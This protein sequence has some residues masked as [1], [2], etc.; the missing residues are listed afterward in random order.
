MTINS[1][2]RVAGPFEGNDSTVSFPFTFKV[3]DS[4]EVRVVAETG[5][6][7]TDLELGTDYTVTLNADQNAAPGGSVVLVNP[8]ATGVRLTLT[9]ALEM[10]QPVDLT[11]QGGFYPRVINSALDRL[12]ILLQQLASVVSRT[13]KFPLSDGPVG[14]LPGRSAR[15]GTVLA[16]DEATGE[17]VVGPDISSVNGVA[18]ALAAINTVAGSIVDVNTV[19]DNIDDLSNFSGVYYG[20]SATD[21]TARRDGSPLQVGDLYFSTVTNTM[22]AY[23]GSAWR[24]SVSGAVT[25]QNLS[26]NGVKTEFLLDY[27]PESEVLTN[28][29]IGG[30]YQQKST[31]ALGGA[32]G[33]VLIFNQ[34]PPVGTDNIE[35]VV[36]S[37]IPSDD[38]LRQ[39]LAAPGGAE[40]VA[41]TQAGAGAVTRTIQE[42]AR[43]TVSAED[44]AGTDAEKLAAGVQALGGLGGTL[45]LT[46][47]G[48]ST[49]TRLAYTTPVS[50][51]GTGGVYAAVDTT[52]ALSTEDTF[53]YS[54]SADYDHT[55]TSVQRLHLG[56]YMDGL[57]AG[58]AGVRLE[59]LSAGQ[60]LSKF[61]VRDVIVGQ[62]S[63]AG[64]HHINDPV[65]NI[66]GGLF[67]A[68]FENSQIKG[69][70]K[71]EAS[72]DSNTISHCILSGDGIGVDASL[73][74]GASLLSIE[75]NNITTS[76]GAIRI[77]AGSRFRIL[78]NNIEHYSLGASDQAVVNIAGGSGTMNSGEIRANLISAFGGTD[79]TR[80]LRLN[81]CQGTVVENNVF[82][83]GASTIAHAI[84]ID[85]NCRDVRIGANVF[86]VGWA[87]PILDNGIGTMGLLK[88]PVLQNGWVGYSATE[89]ARFIKS[90]DGLVTLAGSIKNGTTANGT[91]LFTLPEG[92]WP[93]TVMRS[94]A[95]AYDIAGTTHIAELII[96]VNGSVLVNWAKGAQLSI[97]CTFPA[98]LLANVESDI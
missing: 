44:F 76:G 34:A 96:D 53:S 88:D 75:N 89:T 27:A 83:R 22:R 41:F 51:V 52:G 67:C 56:S 2:T 70:I 97:N 46:R 55:L 62:G 90:T 8:L 84:V 65:D 81:N 16:F 79:A 38:K 69:G 61:T 19:A 18:G 66:N 54:P 71:L 12:T 77:N 31:Y 23:N 5:A 74:S 85:A 93:A 43:E 14:D 94:P 26:G 42:K 39:E 49:P 92:F 24:N 78:G 10:L 68:R 50:I 40:L 37:L 86:S 1:E 33:D 30:V 60:N 35:V 91:L 3:F 82:L 32:N 48:Y 25:I 58:R 15:A 80:L 45:S 20:P 28:V 57:R 11:N 73:V 64:I 36:S 63:G 29:F 7:E 98:A 72:G 6:V 87:G 59:T 13:L 95:Y 17:P 9:S 4:D 47:R 21:P